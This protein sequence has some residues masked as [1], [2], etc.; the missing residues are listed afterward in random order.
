MLTQLTNRSAADVHEALEATGSV[1]VAALVLKGCDIERATALLDRA[2]GQLRLALAL[3][4]SGD[5]QHGNDE[6][7]PPLVPGSRADK[8]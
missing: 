5:D 2:G 4:E 6:R 3:A 1:K 7:A 8:P